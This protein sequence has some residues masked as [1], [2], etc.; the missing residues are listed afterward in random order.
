[1]LISIFGP[2]SLAMADTVGTAP[3]AGNGNG[4]V[5]CGNIGPDG[6]LVECNFNYAMA[7]VKLLMNYM[8]WFTMIIV[9][10]VIAYSGFKYM[11]AGGNSSEVKKANK[12]FTSIVKGLLFMFCAW[13]IVFTIEN[14]LMKTDGEAKKTIDTYFLNPF[15]SN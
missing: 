3:S 7:E 10:G 1:M 5:T 12:M 2:W 8:F 9:T 4:L 14:T 11:L 6:K 15:K 13:I